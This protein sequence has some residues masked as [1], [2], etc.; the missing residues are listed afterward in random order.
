MLRVW[1]GGVSK[2][3][4]AP[5][6]LVAVGCLGL[7]ASCV[8]V[9]PG[10][11]IGQQ[12][13]LGRA[14]TADEAV[15][16]LRLCDPLRSLA[17]VDVSG[18]HGHEEI[19]RIRRSTASEIDLDVVLGRVPPGFVEEKPLRPGPLPSS[20]LIEVSTSGE[21]EDS[22]LVEFSVSGLRRLSPNQ[23]LEAGGGVTSIAAFEA[24]A[25]DRC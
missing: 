8:P 24:E 5:S 13:G 1:T 25:D 2:Q 7:L 20:V 9:D 17:V 23:T 15:I 11:K 16:H 21:R 19:W 10:S 6:A 18:E 3:I 22:D 14:A 12:V 4:R